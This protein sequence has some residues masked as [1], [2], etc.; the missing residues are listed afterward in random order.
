[1]LKGYEFKHD[2]GAA[3]AGGNS[4]QAEQYGS[5]TKKLRSNVLNWKLDL[6][7]QGTGGKPRLL[8]AVKEVAMER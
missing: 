8:A 5:T 2:A 7:V 4:A 3:V 6:N 1:M